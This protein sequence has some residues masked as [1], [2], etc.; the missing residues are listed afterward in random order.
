MSL[1][2]GRKAG[3]QWGLALWVVLLTAGFASAQGNSAFNGRALDADG[4]VLPGVTVTVTNVSTG[5]VRTGVSNAEGVYFLPGLELGTFNITA[6]LPGF[7]TQT[8][9]NVA[10]G[11]GATLTVDFK[12]AIAGLSENVT[13][14]GE[15]PLIE[16]TQSKQASNIEA[17]EIENLPMV[18]RT[19]S[20]M[21]ALLPGAVQIAP[22]HRSKENVGSVSYG[23]GSGTN[24]VPIV[25]GADNR[26]NQFG[27]PLMA[28]TLEG[29]EQF[30]LSTSQF[31]AADGRGAGAAVQMVTKSGT[32]NLHGTAF[33]LGRDKALTSKD[34]FTKQANREKAQFSRQQYG[35]SL[36]G[37]LVRNKIFF[38]GAVEQ[39]NEDS[40]IAVPDNVLNQQNILRTAQAAGRIPSWSVNPNPIRFIPRPATLLLQTYKGNAQLN[41]QHSVMFRYARQNDDRDGVV[42]VASNDM[43]E[44]ENSTIVMWSGVGQHNWV[45]GNS[46]LNQITFQANS[47]YRLSDVENLAGDK[48]TSGFG[49]VPIF[50]PR[51]QFPTVTTGAGGGGGTITDT[52]LFQF[53]EEMSLLKGNHSFKF[54]VNFNILNDIGLL[55][56]NEHFA[57][58]AFFDDPSTIVN[59]TNGR[60]P[61][62]FATPGVIRQWQQANPVF[63]D[64]LIDAKQFMWWFQDDFRVSPKLTLNLGIRWDRDY[65]FY[66]QK[67]FANNATLLAMQ[68]IGHPDARLPVTP[69]RDYS[70]RV[71]FAYDLSGDGRRVLRG[72]YGYYFDYFNQ[73]GGNISDIYSQNR[74]PMNV[75]ATLTNTGY[76]QGQ[77]A[78]YRFGIDPVPAQPTVTDTLPEGADGYFLNPNMKDPRSHQIHI[79]YAHA[80]ADN[81]MLSFDYS[82]IISRNGFRVMNL[83]PIINGQRLLAPQFQRAFGDPEYLNAV[84]N[85]SAINDAQ[86]DGFT[87]KA[88]RRFA[89]L[90]VQAHYTLARSYAYGGNSFARGG[91]PLP[92]V[93]DQPEGPGE[94]GPTATDERHRFVFLG[95]VDAPWGI[96]LSPIFQAATP[97]P[98]NL[99]AGTD[100]NRD[101]NNNDRWIDPATGQQVGINAGRGDKTI[102]LD[103]RTTKFFNLGGAR[104]LGVFVEAYNLLNRANFGNSFNG[105]GRA[106]TFRLPNGFVPGIG[107]PRQVQLGGRFLF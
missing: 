89:R 52:Q 65:Q 95:V 27:G 60:Y 19:V 30:S 41:N 63:A 25:D 94:W 86:W 96:Q 59:N 1:F 75:L 44:P 18:S 31:T 28:F 16:V 105:N 34:Y 85:L 33:F 47:L 57:T 88:I 83:N 12:M 55:N 32:N 92:Q 46:G 35:G 2:G 3:L 104:R 42:A 11:V 26:D 50:P 107:I 45:L 66:D 106:A 69:N 17:K 43:R 14:T 56:A 8:R 9:E 24:V 81:T 58:L 74:R 71:G 93:W 40:G 90:N 82:S 48:Y 38:F 98:Y 70:P 61:Q 101:G 39:M 87:V 7:A 62:G 13:V 100:L 53:K 102:V 91:A 20:S 72:G 51:L 23:G 36:G 6:E 37:P 21:L 68:T 103:L 67:N 76:G 73:N 15:A 79:G 4:A 54:G 80:L 49:A 10:L 22:A 99:T 5:V 64:S 84:N 29:L 97:R 77:L 78:T